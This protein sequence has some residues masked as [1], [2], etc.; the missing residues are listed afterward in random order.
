VPDQLDPDEFRREL[1]IRGT[2]ARDFAVV[3]GVSYVTLSRAMHGRP[4]RPSTLA[5]ITTGLA[6]IPPLKGARRLLGADRG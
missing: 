2:T 1:N 4:M 3:A 5:K 6:R